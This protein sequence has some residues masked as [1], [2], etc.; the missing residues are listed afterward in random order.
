ME[1]LKEKQEICDAVSILVAAGIMDYNGHASIRLDETTFLINSGA[2]NRAAMDI[3]QISTADTAGQVVSGARLPNEVF[4][5]AEIYKARPDVAALLHCHPSWTTLFSA[6]GQNIPCV[7][8]QG[9]LVA[10]LPIYPHSHSISS[11]S[12]GMA[13]AA[14]LGA[15]SGAYLQGHGVVFVGQE[16]KEPVCR[17]IYAEQNAERAYQSLSLG[18]ATPLAD[19]TKREYAETLANPALYKKCWDF[20]LT[21]KVT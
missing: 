18:G 14:C 11:S 3:A 6:C 16:L 5:H 4:L 2:S 13:L 20:F 12:R 7:M 1:R 10:D 15:E 9:A 17:A 8:P 21:Q 19:A